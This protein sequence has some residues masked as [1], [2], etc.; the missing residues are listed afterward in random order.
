M[1]F[2]ALPTSLLLGV[3]LQSHI[4]AALQ[5]DFSAYPEGSQQCLSD[6]ADTSQCSGNT[7]Q[8]LNQCL[9]KNRGNFIY[10]TAQCVAKA[11]PNDLGAVYDTMENNCSGTGVTIAVSKDAF[12]SQALAAT[13]TSSAPTPSATG[14]HSS[15]HSG[16]GGLSTGEKIGMGAGLG[17]GIVAAGLAAVCIPVIYSFFKFHYTLLGSITLKSTLANELPLLEMSSC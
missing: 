11:S 12:M 4:A 13:E 3:T 5:N 16:G 8:Q 1:R 14:G 2:L 9:C 17:L 6:A 10:D 15:G 7:G